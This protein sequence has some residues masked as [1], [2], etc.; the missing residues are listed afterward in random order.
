MLHLPKFATI[1]YMCTSQPAQLSYESV[2]PPSPL[3]RTAASAC[4]VCSC[5]IFSLLVLRAWGR[6][7]GPL[8]FKVSV[9]IVVIGG[10]VGRGGGIVD[11]AGWWFLCW[12]SMGT[13]LLEF[14]DQV[15]D[16]GWFGNVETVEEGVNLF[17][18]GW[19]WWGKLTVFQ[20]LIQGLVVFF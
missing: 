6:E 9:G 10:V 2:A 14:G 16:S 11:S 12:G 1:Q 3:A 18:L 20:M 19:L 8:G 17:Q 5:R 15:L 4:S 13:L 7:V